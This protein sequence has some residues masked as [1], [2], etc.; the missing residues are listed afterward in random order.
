MQNRSF[1]APH[2]STSS[3]GDTADTSPMELSALG[4][5]LDLC[6]ALKGRLFHARCMADS[7]HGFVASRFVTTLVVATLLIGI[8]SL[9]L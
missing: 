5:H 4:E 3:F 7:M 6:K 1:A 2:W 8:S 9:M